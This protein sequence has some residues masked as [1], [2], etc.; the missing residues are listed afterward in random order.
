MFIKIVAGFF[1]ILQGTGLQILS[2][3]LFCFF[4]RQFCRMAPFALFF[5]LLDLF[6]RFCDRTSF[7]YDGRSEEN[8]GDRVFTMRA[9]C[10]SRFGHSL[11]DLKTSAAVVATSFG[12]DSSIFIGWHRISY[13]PRPFPPLSSLPA[14]DRGGKGNV[15]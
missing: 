3:C 7:N 1:V 13:H 12:I 2:L 14:A 5:V 10:Q 11:D 6:I 4:V 9:V 8:P 15:Q